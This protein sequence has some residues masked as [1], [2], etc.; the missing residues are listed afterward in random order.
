MRVWSVLRFLRVWI[1]KSMRVWERSPSEFVVH[2]ASMDVVIP[3]EFE[4]QRASMDI[5]NPCEFHRQMSC[6]YEHF[7]F[8]RVCKT[9]HASFILEKTMRVCMMACEYHTK[10]R[11]CEFVQASCDFHSPCEFGTNTNTCE[12]LLQIHIT[13]VC[14]TFEARLP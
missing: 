5:I 12:F 4:T 13:R 2:H 14:I 10:F 7:Q 11:L 1:S 6:E 3:C 8:M 9:R